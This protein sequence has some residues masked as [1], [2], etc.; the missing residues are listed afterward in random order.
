MQLQGRFIFIHRLS[1][2]DHLL[3]P[4]EEP[5]HGKSVFQMCFPHPGYL[6]VILY[7][8]P[9]SHRRLA[10]GE[11]GRRNI[12]LQDVV[13]IVIEGR[14]VHEKPADVF[15]VHYSG[16]SHSDVRIILD[17][18]SVGS[19]FI[20]TVLRFVV[21]RVHR[22]L[23]DEPESIVPGNKEIRHH[24]RIVL[25][26]LSAHIQHPGNLVKGGNQDGIAAVVLKPLPYPR[27]LLGPGPTHGL[28]SKGD[29]RGLRYRRP[30]FPDRVQHI[31]SIYDYGFLAYRL[32]DV[33]HGRSIHPKAV[34]GNNNAVIIGEMRRQPFRNK[35]L[36][37]NPGLVQFYSSAR[38]L[39]GSLDEIPGVGPDA[40]VV[41]RDHK[42]AFAGKAGHPSGL[43]PSRG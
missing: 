13:E 6:H 1:R 32:L 27:E 34:Y 20:E 30:A 5:F 33:Q 26:I 3:Q 19:Q 17:V 36:A 28:R 11:V 37:G 25:H 29:N 14:G 22:P 7:R 35:H 16:K 41:V 15:S 24:D 12:L 43:Q 42:V 8:L 10:G 38:K 4:E 31:R 9:Q 2:L 18:H 39:P 23:A 21:T 40:G